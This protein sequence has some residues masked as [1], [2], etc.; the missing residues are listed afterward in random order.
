MS[1]AE[2]DRRDALIDARMAGMGQGAATGPQSDRLGA[3][4]VAQ[5]VGGVAALA[6]YVGSALHRFLRPV[7]IRPATVH[8]L[9]DHDLGVRQ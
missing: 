3:G 9:R 1:V 8:H 4:E 6:V 7:D 2:P 5:Q